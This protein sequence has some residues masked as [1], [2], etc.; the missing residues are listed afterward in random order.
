MAEDLTWLPA[1]Q[2]HDL[3][4]KREVSPVEVTEHFLGRIEELDGQLQTFASLDA[5]GAR[6]QAKRAEAAVRNDE[7]LG[8]LHG[9]PVSVKEHIAVAGLPVMDL[10]MTWSTAIEDDIGVERLRKAGAVIFGTNTMLGSGAG[11]NAASMMGEE[12]AQPLYFNWDVE[13]RN[14]WDRS[15]VPGWSSSGGA[16]AAAARLLPITIGSDGG[17]STRLPAAYSGVV[18]VHPQQGRLPHVDYKAPALQLTGTIGP[19]CRH[20]RDAAITTQVLAGPDGRDFVCLQEDAPDYLGGLDQGI[21]GLRIGWTDDFGYAGIYASDESP[22]VIGTIREA[23]FALQ[24][25]GATVERSSAVWEDYFPG[26]FTYARIFPMAGEGEGET[27]LPR[28]T[29]EEYRA[30]AD[31]RRRSW[32]TFKAEFQT[33]DLLLSPTA[34]LVA[35]TV[36][37]WDRAWTTETRSFPH[38]NYSSVYTSHTAMFNWL[39]W[40]AVS[41]PC[42]FVDGLPVGLQIIGLPGTEPLILRAAEAFQQ[43]FPRNEHPPIS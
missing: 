35:P 16:A 9:I 24:S 27:S 23:A 34:Q 15:R 3:I 6:E 29:Q 4:A 33:Y 40:P 32:D 25:I 22:R 20:V 18:G 5:P 36:E 19:L 14:P 28:A 38:G 10:N 26:N 42:G 12:N 31:A 13:A 30:A 39:G 17:G 1:W 7:P 43:A 21:E 2:I 8:P 37:A 11:V 41:V